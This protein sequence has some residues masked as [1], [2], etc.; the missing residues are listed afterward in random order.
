MNQKKLLADVENDIQQIDLVD[1][2]T[3][4]IQRALSKS[5]YFRKKDM[6]EIR[7][8]DDPANPNSSLFE[9]SKGFL[10]IIADKRIQYTCIED[11]ALIVLLH[12]F[13]SINGNPKKNVKD[14][15]I[16][17]E[18]PLDTLSFIQ[19]ICDD[20][21]AYVND[22]QIEINK[23]KN[24]RKKIKSIL[25]NLTSIQSIEYDGEKIR[26]FEKGI[27]R[28]KLEDQFIV[29]FSNDLVKLLSIQTRKVSISYRPITLFKMKNVPY[30]VGSYFSSFVFMKKNMQNNRNKLTIKSILKYLECA[31]PTEEY[32]YKLQGSYINKIMNPV[33]EAFNELEDNDI[34]NVIEENDI[35]RNELQS[36]SEYVR[37]KNSSVTI[38][39]ANTAVEYNRR[40]MHEQVVVQ[41]KR[42]NMRLKKQSSAV[43]FGTKLGEVEAMLL[44]ENVEVMANLL[45]VDPNMI[46]KGVKI[47]T[48]KSK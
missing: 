17:N 37:W 13:I 42:L 36:K 44:S 19:I 23:L 5:G 2:P 3:F 45:K 15:D 24:E 46:K 31:L 16:Q 11:K 22:G 27:K 28:N 48:K 32:V 12:N 47:G 21:D 35:D 41:D 4:E 34:F 18:I 25:D 14:K 26:L 7:N 40:Y 10:K 9:F 8:P 1:F 39:P 33:L 38:S 30:L 29:K 6:N 43:A 20:I